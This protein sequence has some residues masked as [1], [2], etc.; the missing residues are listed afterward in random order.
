MELNL[1]RAVSASVIAVHR[2][3]RN[4]LVQKNDRSNLKCESDF[5]HNNGTAI[6]VAA[7]CA[8]EFPSRRRLIVGAAALAARKI[9]TR[10]L[11]FLKL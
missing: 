8:S 1:G 4:S 10:E 9:A 6:R 5:L 2:V 3:A 7:K 11:V